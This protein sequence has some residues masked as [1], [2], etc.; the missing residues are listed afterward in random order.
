M[1]MSPDIHALSKLSER[2]IAR[3][4]DGEALALIAKLIDG[5]FDAS[6]E[7]G[8]KRALCCQAVPH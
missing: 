3:M 4:D 6:F 2:G 1:S 8:A 5:S 7:R